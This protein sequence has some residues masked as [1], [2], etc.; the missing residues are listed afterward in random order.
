VKPF[1]RPAAYVVNSKQASVC[2]FIKEILSSNFVKKCGLKAQNVL[3]R[4]NP[5][6]KVKL[7]CAILG[8]HLDQTL[9]IC[10]LCHIFIH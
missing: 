3:K 1:V 10:L 6:V 5:A 4:P 7:L 2:S 9:G 8:L